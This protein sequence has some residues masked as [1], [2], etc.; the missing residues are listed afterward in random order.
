MV[1]E[2]PK[3][4]QQARDG[5]RVRL[6]FSDGERRLQVLLCLFEVS[7]APGEYGGERPGADAMRHHTIGSTPSHRHTV[8]TMRAS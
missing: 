6:R 5:Q 7:E 2:K 8:M 4:V 3:I 1:G